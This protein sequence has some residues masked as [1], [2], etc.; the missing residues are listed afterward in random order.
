MKKSLSI[1]KLYSF[2]ERFI[3]TQKNQKQARETIEAY[4]RYLNEH[5]YDV[6][7][8]TQANGSWIKKLW[9]Q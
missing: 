2:A 8:E 3:G 9:K 1:F 4:L 5:K 7:P 6:L